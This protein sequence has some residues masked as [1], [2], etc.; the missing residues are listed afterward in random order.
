MATAAPSAAS[1]DGNVHSMPSPRNWITWPP[2][3][4]VSC[5]QRSSVCATISR[6]RS[7]P[8]VRYSFVLP[9]MSANSTAQF[10]WVSM[11][12]R[13]RCIAYGYVILK[14]S[15]G[16]A[17][18]TRAILVRLFNETRRRRV[19]KLVAGYVVA[20]WGIIQL[21]ALLTDEY[22]VSSHPVRWLFVLAV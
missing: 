22:Q 15:L 16:R 12:I 3:A 1:T 5:D 6:A 14:S 7:S 17:F 4:T 11:G 20:C 9:L 19:L 8:T 13:L 2:S 18:R 10:S 21:V